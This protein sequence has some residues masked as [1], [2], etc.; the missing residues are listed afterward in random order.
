MDRAGPFERGPSESD[1][2]GTWIAAPSTP[3]EPDPV[4]ALRQEIQLS[5]L[6]RV[7]RARLSLAAGGT[8][9]SYLKGEAIGDDKLSAGVSNFAERVLFA[10][11][12]VS[13]D[14]RPGRNVLGATLAR[15]DTR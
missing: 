1:W 15:D 12:D 2:A 5:D 13:A 7:D 11:Y 3:Y 8:V 10:T 14:L 9:R 6:D 4:P